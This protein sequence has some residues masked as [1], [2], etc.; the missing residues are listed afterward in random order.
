MN[1]L[2][3]YAFCFFQFLLSFSAKGQPAGLTLSNFE[4]EILSMNNGKE[5]KVALNKLIDE[6]FN[7]NFAKYAYF[8]EEYINVNRFLGDSNNVSNIYADLVSAY[9]ELGEYDKATVYFNQAIKTGKSCNENKAIVF[10]YSNYATIFMNQ[11]KLD[12]ASN[13]FLNAIKL[14]EKYN[15]FELLGANLANY[16]SVLSV[17]ENDKKL[18]YLLKADSVFKANNIDDYIVTGNIG[19]IYSKMSGQSQNAI[20]YLYKAIELAEEAN[21]FKPAGYNYMSLGSIYFEIKDFNKAIALQ[22]KAL[23]VGNKIVNLPLTAD[24]LESLAN[25]YAKIG[26]SDSII[27]YLGLMDILFLK[28]PKIK[29]NYILNYFINKG[30]AKSIDKEFN[31]ALKYFILAREKSNININPVETVY[32][33]LGNSYAHLGNTDKAIIYLDSAE[34]FCKIHSNKTLIKEIQKTYAFIFESKEDFKNA[35]LALKRSGAIN[36]SNLIKSNASTLIEMQTKYETEKKNNALKDLSIKNLTQEKSIN[37]IWIYSSIGIILLIVLFMVISFFIRRA[38]IRKL[39]ISEHKKLLSQM[40]PHFIANS[41]T[42][43]KDFFNRNPETAGEFTSKFNLLMRD[44]LDHSSKDYISL[45]EELETLV[46]Y[47]ELEKLRVDFT[48]II[49]IVDEFETDNIKVPPLF[50]Q[51][52]VENAIHHGLEPIIEGERLLNIEIILEKGLLT[53][54]VKDNGVGMNF[55][56]NSNNKIPLNKKGKSTAILRGRLETLPNGKKGKLDYISLSNGTQVKI[57]FPI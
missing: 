52:L 54:I 57:I 5:K 56:I 47:I 22:K 36:D 34:Q 42:S 31:E 10:A 21:D 15:Y 50:L 28:K 29:P 44:I 53:Y 39:S 8:L 25:G 7:S 38:N 20:N 4:K 45:D 49:D 33:G 1:N 46:N 55:D 3:K 6:S 17:K 32:W 43:I 14:A 51:P 41:M 11:G 2:I 40:N 18:Y 26:K 27:Y 23:E 19:S 24:A 37:R 13:Y 16:A 12:K 30:L 35:Y 9:G 48:Y